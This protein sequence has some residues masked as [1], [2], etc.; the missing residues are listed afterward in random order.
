MN[1]INEYG[2][3]EQRQQKE[4]AFHRFRLEGT[5]ACPGA[6]DDLFEEAGDLILDVVRRI[7]RIMNPVVVPPLP[8]LPPNPIPSVGVPP[9]P[10]VV[11]DQ[12]HDITPK[13]NEKETRER[14][15]SFISPGRVLTE[16]FEEINDSNRAEDHLKGNST[17]PVMEYGGRAFVRIEERFT[18]ATTDSTSMVNMESS[19][20][21]DRRS[22]EKLNKENLNPGEA[23]SI[24][25]YKGQSPVQARDKFQCFR[26]P[27]PRDKFR[28][29]RV[30]NSRKKRQVHQKKYWNN[31]TKHRK[32]GSRSPRHRKSWSPTFRQR[33]SVS[34]LPGPHRTNRKSNEKNKKENLDPGIRT[35][36]GHASLF[37]PGM[38]WIVPSHERKEDVTE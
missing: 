17:N 12:I 15:S 27:L 1:L 20:Q 34:Q 33:K 8:V 19:T 5:V 3:Q 2:D 35:P 30:Q 26:V 37:R 29:V 14:K 16:K 10:A 25:K 7:N 32:Y 28:R 9:I 4:E 11:A 31:I 24:M 38:S 21:L 18:W 23:E 22:E 6:I 36:N 13:T